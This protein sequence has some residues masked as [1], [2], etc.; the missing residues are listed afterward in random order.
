MPDSER[1]LPVPV[2]PPTAV[3]LETGEAPAP[4]AGLSA[5]ARLVLLAL[6]AIVSVW[7]AIELRDI[8][9]QVLIATILAAGIA[10]LTRVL[11]RIGLPSGV[12]VILIYLLLILVIVGLGFLLVPPVIA[13][14]Q[15]LISQAPDFGARFVRSLQDLQ[16]QFPFLPP[17][18]PALQNQLQQVGNSAGAIFVQALNIVGVAL[19]VFGGLL[20]AILTLLITF[21]LVVDGKRIRNY[22][23]SFLPKSQVPRFARMMDAIGDRMGGWLLGQI[24][25]STSIGIASFIALLLVGVNNAL[26]L[27]VVAAVAELLP[28]IGPWIAA[29][30]AVIV[31]FT[32][33]PVKALLTI[34]A[35]VIIQQIESNLLAPRIMGR[36]VRLHPL[37]VIL[38]LLAGA[39]LFG[40]VG[41]LVAVPVAAAVSVV[42]D[43]VRAS[44]AAP[45]LE[46]A[47]NTAA[48]S[49]K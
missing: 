25:L 48:A 12:S 8:L 28:I 33:D 7:L 26:L 40:I 49:G 20:T 10:P 17:L 13:E 21:Y 39:S 16:Q 34:I 29:I 9:I 11:T 32:Q 24:A 41:A 36:A 44:R 22:L 5:P 37:A 18:G 3:I 43:E 4:R 38:A 45:V 2:E 14:V 19:G 6:A 31:A 1:D 27:A 47:A 46:D 35:Y 23:L 30:P 42:L 15:S